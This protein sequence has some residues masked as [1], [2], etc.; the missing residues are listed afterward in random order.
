MTLNFTMGILERIQ[1]QAALAITGAWKGTNRNK[2]YEE[3]G[4][5]TLDLR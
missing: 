5:E 3:L 1:Y 2:I 4:F